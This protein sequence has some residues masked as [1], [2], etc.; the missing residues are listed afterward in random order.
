MIEIKE[1]TIGEQGEVE[2]LAKQPLEWLADP[3]KPKRS[4]FAAMVTVLSAKE[5]K[6]ITYSDARKL[7]L[8][9]LLEHIG[10]SVEDLIALGNQQQVGE[11]PK[12]PKK[13]Q[14]HQKKS[15]TKKNASTEKNN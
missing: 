12:A 1:L 10:W 15:T 13:P 2:D 3:D 11:N 14:D 6:P 8:E 5:N 9:E 4:L 7:S